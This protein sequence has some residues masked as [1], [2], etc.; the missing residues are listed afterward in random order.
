MEETKKTYKGLIK[1]CHSGD[2]FIILR[3]MKD[4][5]TNERQVNLASI[6]A[7]KIGSQSR[8]EEAFAFDARELIRERV[9]G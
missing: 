2:Q 6:Q 4:G 8:S 3:T 9:A 7:P 5:T 1:S